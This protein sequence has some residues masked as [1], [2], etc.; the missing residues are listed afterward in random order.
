[1]QASFPVTIREQAGIARRAEPTQ[2]SLP[3]AVGALKDETAVAITDAGGNRVPAQ[4]DVLARWT[5][6]SIRWLLARFLVVLAPHGTVTLNVQQAASSPP[7][8]SP[9]LARQGPRNVVVETG[10]IR[11][12]VGPA[13][14]ESFVVSDAQGRVLLTQRPQLV[15]YSPTG[16]EFRCAPPDTVDIEQN[17]PLYASVFLAGPM[18]SKDGAFDALFRYETR[19]HLWRGLRRVLAEHTVVAIGSTTDGVTIVDGIVVEMK[20]A[21]DLV[22]TAFAGRPKTHTSGLQAGQTLRLKQTCAY[23][24]ECGRGRDR[25]AEPVRYVVLEADFGYELS[26]NTEHVLARGEKADGWLWAAGKGRSV[27]VAVRDFWEEGPKAL[28]V[29]ADGSLGVEC[30]AHWQAVPGERRPPRSRTPDY[31]KHPRLAQWFAGKNISIDEI[32][33]RFLEDTAYPGPVR[34]GP[35]RFGQGRAKTT[36]VLYLFGTPDRRQAETDVLAA[37]RH[38]LIP[39]VDPRY[40]ASTRALPFVWLAACDS[41][42]PVF[43]QGLRQMFNNWKAHATRYGFLHYGD[44]QC[45]FGYNKTVPATTDDQEYDTTQCLTMQFARTGEPDYLRWANVCARHFMDVDQVHPTGELHFHGYTAGGDYHE[46]PVG[47]DMG[48]HP[49]IGGIVNHYML[50]GDRRSLR[51][52]HRLARAL[53]DYG[54]DAREQILTTDE[55]S[56]ARA[57]ICLAAIYDLT[58]DPNHLAPVKRVANAISDLSGNVTEALKGKA[59]FH[60]WWIN[61]NEMCYHV[62]ELLVRYHAATG[63]QRTLA[64]LEE[65]LDLYIHNL[66]DSQQVAWRGMFGAPFDFNMQYENAV[67]REPRRGT[68]TELATAELGMPFAYVAGVTGNEFYLTPILES[69]DTL[70]RDFA[71]RY[72]NRQFARRQLW[73]LPLVSMLP[74]HWRAERD[75]IVQRE[76]FRASLKKDDGLAAWTPRGQARGRLHGEALWADSPFGKVLRTYR[77]S[78]VTFGAPEDILALP[79][80]MSVWVRKDAAQWDRKPWPWYGELRGLIYMGS[81]TRETNAL[82]LMMLKNDLWTRLYDHRAWEMVAIRSPSPLWAGGKWHHIA[83]VWNRYDLTVFINGEQ[84]GHDDRF[85]LPNGGQTTIT[86]GW[87]P[88]NRYGQANYYDLRVFRTA[89]PADRIKRIYESA[90]PEQ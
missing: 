51:G 6:G 78:F 15:L 47:V 27:G 70:G 67:P 26:A 40:V 53:H 39:V 37:R 88:T 46:E 61:H 2:V 24:H 22:T 11:A 13:H 18:K 9:N 57:G 68:A 52:I 81:E 49:Y 86:L 25:V 83:V 84:V 32:V 87:R 75:R 23:W 77:N 71:K 65:A 60:M 20:A 36:D 69:M 3:F 62:R 19:L 31:S 4:F 1:L 74:R 10:M 41:S 56:L 89:L 34:R 79:G 80:T 72:G 50:T 29:D 55:R 66:W 7:V 85:A 33:K 76:V 54:R 14:H 42:L 90:R 8:Q 63:D 48:G 21:T 5:D 44:D 35:F 59:P 17:G 64:T 82:D 38:M 58:R 73:S 43:E 45:A 12:V 28:R 30:Y 16:G